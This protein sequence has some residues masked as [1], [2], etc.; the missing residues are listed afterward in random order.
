MVRPCSPPI[1][2][3]W[4]PKWGPCEILGKSGPQLMALTDAAIR[5]LI[6][7]DKP[8]KKADEKGLFLLLQPSGGKLWRFK[9]RFDG[10]EKK[11]GLGRYPDVS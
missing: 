3:L 9:Y 11:L 5:A 2:T 6:H 7:G 1:A 10:K 4:G 8:S